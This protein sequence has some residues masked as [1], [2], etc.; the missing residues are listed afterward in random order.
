METRNIN[1]EIAE[2]LGWTELEWDSYRIETYDDILEVE[3]WFGG[4]PQDGDMRPVPDYEHDLNA[5]ITLLDTLPDDH[6]EYHDDC[7]NF[8]HTGRLG[9]A[10]IDNAGAYWSVHIHCF[11]GGKPDE[12]VYDGG[13]TLALAICNTWLKWKRGDE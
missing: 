8:L 3:T 9:Y 5:A 13:E 11:G 6:E 12:D 1:R 7:G 10:K 4:R 2:L